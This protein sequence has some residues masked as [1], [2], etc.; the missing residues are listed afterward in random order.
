MSLEYISDKQTGLKEGDIV[1][2]IKSLDNTSNPYLVLDDIKNM[3][4]GFISDPKCRIVL[5]SKVKE[6]INEKIVESE[7]K[8][9]KAQVVEGPR[10]PE[11]YNIV[12]LDFFCGLSNARKDLEESFQVFSL[13][14]PGSL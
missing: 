2:L 14:K 9:E 5:K 10:E 13:L 3:L 4:D 7:E 12:M 6:I 8:A 11:C 1:D